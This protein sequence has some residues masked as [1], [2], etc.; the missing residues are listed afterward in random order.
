MWGMSEPYN[1]FTG[2]SLE[3][4]T[5]LSDGLFAVAMTLLVLD[6]RVPVTTA[7]LPG[8]TCWWRVLARAFRYRWP[9]CL[10]TPGR[11]TLRLSGSSAPG[12]AGESRGIRMRAQTARWVAGC[13][14]AGSVAL[15][16]AGLVLAYVDRYSL[17]AGQNDWNLPEV[18]G[19]VV[20]LAVPVVGFVLA[21]RRPANRIGWV[22]LAAGL[23]LGLSAFSLQ[24]ALHALV[25]APGS[26]PA[27]RAFA[28]LSNWTWVIAFAMLAF[29][30]L[31]FPTGRLC[32]RRWRPAAWFVGAVFAATV[33]DMVVRATRLWRD[34]FGSF[35]EAE[36]PAELIVLLFLI[37]AALVISV[38]AVVV[39]YARSAGDERLQL[40]W[41]AAA[42]LLVVATFI[43]SFLTTWMVAGVLSNLAFL[44]LWTA[45]GIAVLKY[46][47]YDIDIVISKAV[48]YGSLAVFI[49]AVYAALVVGVG[50]LVGNRRNALLA[51]LAAA[52]VAVA[53]QPARQRAGRLANR[54]VYG[55][56]A[57]RTRCCPTS[58]SASAARM[59]MRM[60]CR[61]WRRSWR[62]GPAPSRLWCGCGWTTSCAR[63]LPRAMARTR[64]RFRSMA[65]RC[66]HCPAVTCASRSCT[67]VS[68]WARSRSGC[69]RASR[70]A[71]PA[72]SS[73]RT[74]RRR[75]AWSCRTLA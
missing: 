35:T 56:R 59:R 73:S 75:Q 38:A 13:I 69:R 40:K 39:R 71:R 50:A 51:A 42:A 48:L 53:F 45:I 1:R 60:S 9:S 33:V 18:F 34:P 28:W 25:A 12:P 61:G 30:F 36:T 21:S 58:P 26:L 32:S 70:S 44:C 41:F 6:L 8:E 2:Q 31:L 27:G 72:S 22:F 10:P 46:R 64:L 74:W 5:A 62:R 55:R 24:Y 4:L 7:A 15:I 43:P 23:T 14:A 20:N 3:R 65:R 16:V 67:R 37:V 68:S 47:L 57:T 49:T 66:R 19:Q 11:A 52:V 63:R 17:P 29:L 54:I